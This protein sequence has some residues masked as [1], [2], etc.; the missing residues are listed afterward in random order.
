LTDSEQLALT[1]PKAAK[2]CNLT[3]AGFDAWVKK[4]IVPG[5]I[6][7]TRRWSKLAIVRALAGETNPIVVNP[8]DPESVYEDWKRRNEN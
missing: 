7:G 4:G 3:P 2:L 6:P 8:D 5:P 1:R